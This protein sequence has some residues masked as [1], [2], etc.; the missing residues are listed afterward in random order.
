MITFQAHHECPGKLGNEASC[1][2]ERRD[3]DVAWATH[4]HPWVP[5]QIWM[6]AC[7]SSSREFTM[8]CWEAEHCF[9]EMENGLSDKSA[10]VKANN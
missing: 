7:P 5:I 10:S 9:A 4:E 8:G 3:A 2:Q 1:L 6:W